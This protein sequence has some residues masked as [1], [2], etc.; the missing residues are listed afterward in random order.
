M[1][2]RQADSYSRSSSIKGTGLRY[3]TGGH[4]AGSIADRE[5]YIG[6]TGQQRAERVGLIAQNRRFLVL[7]KQRMPN[8]A[9]H[10]IN[11]ELKALLSGVVS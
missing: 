9:N 7:G 2:V 4:P 8:L 1:T 3:W 11:V 6:W 5:T 10:V